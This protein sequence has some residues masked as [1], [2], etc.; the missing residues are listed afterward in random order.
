MSKYRVVVSVP[1]IKLIT[2]ECN[3]FEII[4]DGRFLKVYDPKFRCYK[5]IPMNCVQIEEI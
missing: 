4:E 3:D 2:I 1:S 5:Y